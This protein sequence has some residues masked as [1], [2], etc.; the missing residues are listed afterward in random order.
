MASDLLTLPRELLIVIIHTLVQDIGIRDG[1]TL[2]Y[3]CTAFDVLVL[4]AIYSLPTFE[5]VDTEKETRASTAP[6]SNL[7][8][9]RT[10]AE[11]YEKR[12][13]V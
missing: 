3:V 5:N 13:L 4:D 12:Y 2:R 8:H 6:R 7:R 11:H 10:H 9:N 1:L